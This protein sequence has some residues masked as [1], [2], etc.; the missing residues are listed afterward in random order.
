MEEFVLKDTQATR[1]LDHENDGFPNPLS[2]RLMPRAWREKRREVVLTQPFPAVF[3]VGGQRVAVVVPTGFVSDFASL[4]GFAR[5]LISPFGSWA[6]PSVVHDWLYAIGTKGDRKARKLA[7]DIFHAALLHQNVPSA[8]I[9]TMVEAVRKSGG[10]AFGRPEEFRFC[11]PRDACTRLDLKR[12][13]DYLQTFAVRPAPD[14]T[15]PARRKR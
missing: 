14:E 15:P 11:D 8:L 12:H 2:I 7:D 6:E 13:D 5:L 4:P 10:I 9:A 3:T 1:W